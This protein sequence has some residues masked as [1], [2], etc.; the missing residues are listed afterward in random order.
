MMLCH[1]CA[2]TSFEASCSN[3]QE[4]P[5]Q[6][7]DMNKLLPIVKQVTNKLNQRLTYLQYNSREKP[8]SIT[9]DFNEMSEKLRRDST[10]EHQTKDYVFN[11]TCKMWQQF[12]GKIRFDHRHS[13]IYSDAVNKLKIKLEM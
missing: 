5:L 4:D 1:S 2:R 10:P 12:F 6:R 7:E 3:K 9:E 11:Q 8:Q 13:N